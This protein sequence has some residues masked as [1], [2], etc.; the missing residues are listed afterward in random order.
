MGERY[1]VNVWCYGWY[2]KDEQYE[3]TRQ[4]SYQD[5]YDWYVESCEEFDV[6]PECYED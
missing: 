6:E 5:E 2:Y 3:Q 4:R 1:D